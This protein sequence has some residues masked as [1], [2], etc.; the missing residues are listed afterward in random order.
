MSH[1]FYNTQ[2]LFLCSAPGKL[3]FRKKIHTRKSVYCKHADKFMDITN[4]LMNELVGCLKTELFRERK[5]NLGYSVMNVLGI[6]Y[7]H[8]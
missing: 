2:L 6:K 7:K 3:N 5:D 1:S 4:L 8:Y